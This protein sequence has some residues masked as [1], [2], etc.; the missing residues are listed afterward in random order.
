MIRLLQYTGFLPICFALALLCAPLSLDAQ[1]DSLVRPVEKKRI[2]IINSDL[3]R[4]IETDSGQLSRMKGNV[5]MEHNKAI[6][7]CDSAIMYPNNL[8]EAM[9]HAQITSGS[10]TV[11][12]EFMTYDGKTAIVWGTVTY[13]MDSTSTLRTSKVIFDTETEIGEFVTDGTIVDSSRLIEARKGFYHSKT[14]EFEFFGAVEADAK[15]YVLRSD[16]MRYNSNTKVF[17]FSTHTHIWTDDGYLYSD[18][19]WYDS[20]NDLMFFY[21]NSYILSPKQE[22]FA[23]SVYYESLDK[24]G[25][26]YSRVQIVDTA[27]NVI[28][29][30]DFA[31]FNMNTEDFLMRENS[32]VITFDDK[33]TT[34]MRADT[35]ISVRVLRYPPDSLTSIAA[36]SVASL[37]ADTAQIA[38][39]LPADTAQ[40]AMMD[41][42]N[43]VSDTVKFEVADS[44]NI[45]LDTTRFAP[46]DSLNIALD[47][48]QFAPTDSLNITANTAQFAS[49]D[50]LN[51]AADSAGFAA[52]DSLVVQPLDSVYK[53]LYAYRNVKL[54]RK[55]FQLIC[56]SLFFNDTDSIWKAYKKPIVWNGKKMQIHSDSMHFI[57][58]NGVLHQALFSGKAMMISPVG[59]NLDSA[60]YY[61]QIK[62][63]TI[64]VY[65]DNQRVKRL[66]GDGNLQTIAFSMSDYSVNKHDAASVKMIFD[67]TEKLRFLSYYVDVSGFNK[68][69]ILLREDEVR[70]DGLEPKF[71]LRPA[72][73]ADVVNRQIRASERS[74]REKIPRPAFPITKQFDQIEEILF[75]NNTRDLLGEEDKEE[76]EKEDDI[77]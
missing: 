47:T 1:E 8:F 77:L 25:K 19:G 2:K 52:A 34:Y 48:T 46:P 54:Y 60:R 17:I 10:T 32:S 70:L 62:A 64:E 76:E 63:K 11:S 61:N 35:I 26:L 5:E 38:S 3:T 23:D 24:K 65:F 73:G 36:D 49:S 15:T 28:A 51:I 33:D 59:D 68:P 75:L 21:E 58:K 9:G 31:D 56:D 39:E 42:L 66:D 22:I 27:K 53:Q 50:T 57:I 44:L 20:E 74:T 40:F 37:T 67:S 7:N 55:D 45:A 41:T 72:S 43:I 12:G 18:R 30:T 29:V 13:L 69:I 16:S 6:L 71:D 14:K 4:L